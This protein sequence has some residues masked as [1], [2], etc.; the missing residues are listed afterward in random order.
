MTSEQREKI[1]LL[2]YKV[3]DKC[4]TTGSNTEYYKKLFADMSDTKFEAFIKRRLPFRF[5][6]SVFKVEPKMQDVFDAFKV[7]NKPLIERVN[8]KYLFNNKDGKP[9]KSQPALVI[10][11][12]IKRM[13]QMRIKKTNTAINIAKRDMKTGR[14]IA[15]DK[16]GLQSNKEFD[17]AA[18]LGLDNYIMENARIKAD[19]MQ[20]KSE[21]YNLINIKGEVSVNDIKQEKT[22]SIAKNSMNVYLVGAGFHTNL[23]DEDYYTPY[24]IANRKGTMRQS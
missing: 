24:T 19:A 7:L 20:A 10:Y 14:L 4:D 13:K 15:E 23:I 16:G 8:L 18:A 6:S 22:D 2:V 9:V 5:H 1:E 3:M 21:A 17:N 11:C 12:N